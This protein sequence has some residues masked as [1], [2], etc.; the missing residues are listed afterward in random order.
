[1][2]IS[3][4][5]N[6]DLELTRQLTRITSDI[7]DVMDAER[8]TLYLWDEESGELRSR[9]VLADG[10]G[11]IRLKLGEGIAGTVMQ[12]G[13][14]VRIDD[15]TLDPRFL[16][17]FDRESGFVTRSMLCQPLA[18]VEGKRIGVLQI[19]NKRGGPFDERD[20]KLL[21]AL[22]SQTAIAIENSQLVHALRA[23]QAAE[24]ALLAERERQ[25]SELA[26]ARSIQ[27]GLLPRE[28]HRRSDYRAAALIEPAR[29]VGGDLYDLFELDEDRIGLVIGDVSGKGVPAALFMA[30]TR[31]LLRALALQLS[32]PSD[33]LATLNSR[34]AEENPSTMFVTLFYGIFDR[35]DRVLRFA[36]GG[37]NPPFLARAD[38]EVL[39][40]PR[41]KGIA[42]GVLEAAAYEEGRI[43]LFPGDQLLLYTDGL[44]EAMNRANDLFGD[45][46]ALS[47][48]AERA[49]QEP[50]ELLRGLRHEVAAHVRGADA[51]DDL[52]LLAL[53]IVDGAPARD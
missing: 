1:M 52:T 49:D 31:T 9:V 14:T 47:A 46:R 42:L 15:V 44:T 35:R 8:A 43:E 25:A 48:F 7:R 41:V 53:Q 32:K 27:M 24:A 4:A 11:E 3:R 10:I 29:E 39:V 13:E 6:P 16:G 18:N 23:S 17:R 20:V 34:L 38:G 36:S 21:E 45:E 50:E 12:T 33:L 40:F 2:A 19:L 28:L 5:E 37:H 51:S 26:I 30:I 22:D